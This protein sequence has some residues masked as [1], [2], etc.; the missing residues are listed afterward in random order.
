MSNTSVIAIAIR[1]AISESDRFIGCRDLSGC[2][3]AIEALVIDRL[4]N[5]NQKGL[6]TLTEFLEKYPALKEATC[7]LQKKYGDRLPERVASY[8][9]NT[10]A[11]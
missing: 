11:D 2:G 6:D 8:R 9:Q 1:R 3:S 10:G 7:E 4:L 5:A